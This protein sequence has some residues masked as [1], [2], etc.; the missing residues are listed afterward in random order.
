M[1]HHQQQILAAADGHDIH[2][3][4]W[5][6]ESKASCVIQVLHG[7]GEYA[8]RYA[9]FADVAVE[10]GYTV[11][12]HDHRGHGG[13]GD[14]PGHFADA[15]GWHELISDSEVV[16]NFVRE[17]YKGR[18]VIL[19]GHSMGSYIAQAFAMRF[20]DRLS[21]LILSASNWPSKL[22]LAPAKILAKIETWRLGRR[23]KSELL[24]QLGFGNFNKPFAPARTEFD[25]LSRDETEVD[26][27]VADP[28][29]GGPYSCA[30]WLDLIGGLFE[31]SS[32]TAIAQVPSILPILITGGEADPVGGDKGMTRLAMHYAQTAHQRLA[33]KIYV[34]GRH[35]MLNE[36]NRD[37]VTADWLNWI[38]TT[39][40]SGHSS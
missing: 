15:E 24:D 13:H 4:R 39:T 10:R 34:G 26:K 12:A 31:L 33:V 36:I 8:D 29:C 32:D 17:E 5:E 37:E 38:A 18:P 11:C 23:G 19:L 40:R 22:Q 16:N 6:P 21:G 3:W 27:Y 35:E 28:L 7:L 1:L 2:V 30:L 9:R 25:W 20:G 14:K